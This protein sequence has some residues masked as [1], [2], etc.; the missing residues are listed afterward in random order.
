M[1]V[2]ICISLLTILVGLEKEKG[3]SHKCGPV[4]QLLLC[5]RNIE[6][7]LAEKGETVKKLLNDHEN[8]IE[9]TTEDLIGETKSIK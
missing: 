4:V 1:D 6:D 3:L 8:S 5:D 2:K 9:L 7:I